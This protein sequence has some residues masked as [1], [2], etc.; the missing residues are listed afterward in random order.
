MVNTVIQEDIA[1]IVNESGLPWD[2][3]RNSTVLISGGNGFLAAYLVRTL[4]YLNGMNFNIQMILLV[5]S[6]A[7]ARA[8]YPEF[9][10][11][12]KIRFLVQDVCEPVHT[13]AKID[14]IIHAASNAS[15]KYFGLDPVGTLS[16][17]VIGT[18]NLLALAREKKV[19]S[20]LFISSGEV[21]GEVDKS[22]I[23]TKETDYGYI[24]LENVRTCY[25]E[26]KRMGEA[27]CVS[28][29]HQYGVPAVIVRPFHTYGPGMRLDDGRVFA[30]FVSNIVHNQD[31]VMKS[32]GSAVRAFCYIADA[33]AGF[34]TVL[35]HGEKGQAYNIGNDNGRIT[36]L[37]LAKVLTG[38]Y[39]E[40]HLHIIEDT[41]SQVQGY[42][43]S[44]I[45]ENCPDISK[46]RAL[47]WAPQTGIEQGFRR[48]VESFYN[49]N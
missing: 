12:D 23:P 27:M 42:L 4:M 15:P 39:P 16:A 14:Y 34:F 43:Q 46:A 11:G 13:D 31:I 47:G 8:V 5:R 38:L 48:T 45:S 10:F 36:I 3:F 26:S 40:K 18:N 9:A 17:N 33:A 19:K 2:R 22:K 28:W 37:D 24:D 44:S 35:L 7:R 32:D 41:S 30:D 29:H 25:Q 21:Y 49:N 1:G 6:E 20:F